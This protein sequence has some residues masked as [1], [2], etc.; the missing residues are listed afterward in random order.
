M[1]N[2]SNIFALVGGGINPKYIPNKLILWDD[3]QTKVISEL[4]FSSDV[5]G[6]RL[7]KDK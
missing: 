6:V 3:H 1:L 5:K 4:R 7:K 2:K